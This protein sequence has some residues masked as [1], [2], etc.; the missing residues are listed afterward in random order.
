ML[1]NIGVARIESDLLL[2]FACA[3]LYPRYC[4]AVRIP[5]SPLDHEAKRYR[6]IDTFC[7]YTFGASLL[8][9]EGVETKDVGLPL[10]RS[11]LARA[12]AASR[13][14]RR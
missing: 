8:A 12:P 5:P 2:G 9:D 13:R 14:E 7:F 11:G 6:E 10:L 1:T 3:V 4:F